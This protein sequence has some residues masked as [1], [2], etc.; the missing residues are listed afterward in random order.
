MTAICLTEHGHNSSHV[1]LEKACKG[2]SIKP[3]YGCEL[4]VVHDNWE[5]Q[6]RKYHQIA[7]AIN[8]AGYQNL[9]R[10]VSIA[11]SPEYQY[12][13]FP[14]IT[15][16]ILFEYSE[17][18]VVTSGCA[19]SLLSCTLLG[20]KNMGPK[21]LEYTDEQYQATVDLAR[22]Y[23]EVFGKRYFL[24][25]QRFPRLDR[26]RVL[27]PA[28]ERIGAELGIELVATADVHYPHPSDN[29][30]QRILHAANRG[31]G[32]TIAQ[33]DAEWEYD[34]LL[35]YPE[36]DLEIYQD[37]IATGLSPKAAKRSV[38]NTAAIA[39]RCTVEL[40]KNEPIKWPYPGSGLRGE[41]IVAEVENED[42]GSDP[43]VYSSIEEYTWARLRKGWAFR[44]NS[45]VN[46]RKNKA[47][48]TERV[49]YEMERIIPRGFCDYF[50][51]LSYL[52]TWAKDNKIP[53]GPARGSAAAS[54]V[55]YLLRI[56]EVDPLQF[57]TMMFERFIDPKRL[58]LPDVDLDFAD[59]RRDEVRQEAIRVFG[60]DRVGNIGN[61][62][63]YKG[64]NSITDV[65]KVYGI[66]KFD[67]QI[68]K[69]LIIERSGGDSRQNDTLMDTFEMFPKAAE[70]LKKHPQLALASKLEGNYRGAGVHAAGLVISNSSI[71][72]TCALHTQES[73]G[74]EITAVPYDKKDAE[75]LGMLKADFLGLKTMGEIGIMI[76]I[77]GIDLEDLYRIPLDDQEVMDAFRRNDVQGIFQ[78]EGRATRVTCDRVKPDNFMELAD[79]NALSRPGPLFS[80]MTDHYIKVKWGDMEI[81]KLH[82]IVDEYTSFTKGQIVYQEQ[83][84]GIIKDLG[85]FPVQRVGDIRK[86]ISQKLGE[87][88]FNEMYEEF[89]SGA[90][91]LHGVEPAL[92]KRIWSFMV[93]SAT[94]SFCVTGD[95]VLERAGKG[96]HCDDLEV[97]VEELY[98]QQHDRSNIPMSDK[99]RSGR[100]NILGMDDDGRI[101][102]NCLIKIHDPVEYH[103]SKITT[104]TG[105]TVTFSNDHQLLTDDGYKHTMELSVGDSVIVDAGR[106]AR[107][108]EM[109]EAQYKGGKER[110]YQID[111][112][113][114]ALKEAQDQAWV[115]DNG[116]CSHCGKAGSRE[117]HTLEF[118]HIMPLEHFGGKFEKYHNINNLM[119]L[120]NSCHK[121]YDYAIQ[122]T[123][124][125]RWTRGRP[126]TIEQIVS[127]DDAGVQKVYD[128]SMKG[129]THNY[130]G[131]GFIHHNNIAHCVSYSM[132][133]FWQMWLKIHDP[134][135]F[136]YAK[137]EKTP[138]DKNNQDKIRKYMKDAVRHGVAVAAPHLNKSTKSWAYDHYVP[139][140]KER[141][142]TWK[143]G[144][145]LVGAVH[146][147]F[148]QI[149]GIGDSYADNIL[150]LRD[151]L[152]GFD[153]WEDL[154]GAKGI[155]PGR[156]DKILD[157]VNKDDPFDV[158]LAEHILTEYRRR[159]NLGIDGWDEVLEPDM[160][161]DEVPK[162]FFGM[163]TWMG[164]VKKKEFKDL[165]EDERAR[166]GESTEEI[167][168]RL[169]DPHLTKS[170]TLHCYDDGDEEIY[171]RISRWDY[172]EL[173]S[174]LEE[175]EPNKDVIVI[176]G[177]RKRM[178]GISVGV[179]NIQ[180]IDPTEDIPGILEN[181]RKKA[182]K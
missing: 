140:S 149:K 115:R 104:N 148:T 139:A 1:Q 109:R 39:K 28:F 34:I 136:Y 133:A 55:C 73:G 9:N 69:D 45:N 72:D 127:I 135:A 67:T 36:S 113:T 17:G 61:F 47:A 129:P 182:G 29:K 66:P 99:I 179:K 50:G 77:I 131:N 52:V 158:R 33:A 166:S 71:P 180:V 171:A 74:R 125:K 176:T 27:N 102:P 124:K 11:N 111:G 8:E 22:Q 64:K 142:A 70:V 168:A 5:E 161:S 141:I 167:M 145:P 94:Y 117:G 106:D 155:G 16:H 159:I 76:D 2:T 65:A 147:G 89:E 25:V 134:V 162:D 97:T 154:L 68:V 87:A 91:R 128:I 123:R 122:G 88:S 178:F 120:C 21:R 172:P 81:E 114:V 31:G 107:T 75:Y 12:D 6:R 53:V 118:A 137:L 78:F 4:Y 80:G 153:S 163:F 59:D 23:Q 48:Y 57:P 40:P 138:N 54:L 151:R 143:E 79:I 18:L 170:C 51:M 98:R 105:R 37:M 101:R 181:A 112:R 100:L 83:V 173:E 121:K 86:I 58:D 146:A 3:M 14:T 144:D 85:G 160:T 174:L 103:C 46:M 44:I 26:T 95:T 62:T 60:S 10:I 130:L 164:M 92:A 32:K 96:P 150:N 152:G 110:N 41:D 56:T 63:R 24:E 116:C 49:K 43:R 42:D 156:L 169:K 15:K 20:G 157:F 84:L 93:T 90:M 19:D 13:R 82:P 132:L 38:L 175:I 108:K 119:V 35:T 7:I 177:K 30:M 126:T 165:M